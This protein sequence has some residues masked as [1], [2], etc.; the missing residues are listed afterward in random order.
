MRIL[1]IILS[2]VCNFSVLANVID[3][4]ECEELKSNYLEAQFEVIDI[5]DTLSMG[6]NIWSRA[7]NDQITAREKKVDAQVAVWRA[8]EKLR[9]VI[10]EHNELLQMKEKEQTNA[11][12]EVTQRID[13]A[14][15]HTEGLRE[16]YQPSLDQAESA[17]TLAATNYILASQDFNRI[18]ESYYTPDT[19]CCD[20]LPPAQKRLLDQLEL[21]E[22]NADQQFSDF[23]I[24]YENANQ[25]PR[26]NCTREERQMVRTKNQAEKAF[27]A[28]VELDD[29]FDNLNM[30]GPDNIADLVALPVAGTSLAARLHFAKRKS[31]SRHDS[32]KNHEKAYKECILETQ[33]QLRASL[34]EVF[35]D[36]ELL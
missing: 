27:A 31:D 5:N 3:T 18:Q 36:N 26:K 9:P 23:F 14:I 12:Q 22:E 13:Q 17:Y 24:C 10:Q 35:E 33:Q 28:Y 29:R 21:A 7:L 16:K 6:F 8:G 4:P 15:A 34:D 2:V 11:S 20:E 25:L 32:F 19:G 1:I 30:N